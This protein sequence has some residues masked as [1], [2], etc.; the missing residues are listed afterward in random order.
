M[1]PALGLKVKS[2]CCQ[3]LLYF[4]MSTVLSQALHEDGLGSCM[5]I[6]IAGHQLPH[7]FLPWQ[8]GLYVVRTKRAAVTGIGNPE[9][10][11]TTPLSGQAI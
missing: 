5:E 4:W 8:V 1:K 11:I 3:A 9:A 10:L 6:M 2:L 7:N